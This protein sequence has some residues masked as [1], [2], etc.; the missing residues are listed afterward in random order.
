MY[1]AGLFINEVEYMRNETFARDFTLPLVAGFTEFWN[2]FLVNGSDGV[3][4]DARASA[5]DSCFE[6][7]VCEDPVTTL[8]LI[9]R[10]ASVQVRPDRY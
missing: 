3:L 6:G 8:A 2:C 1:A 7:G 5:R 10:M 4:H 9:K